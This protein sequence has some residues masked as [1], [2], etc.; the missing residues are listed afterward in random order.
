MYIAAGY[1]YFIKLQNDFL[2]YILDHGE[3][4]PYLKCYF[5]NI[6][7]KIPIYEAN[8][9]QILSINSMFKSSEYKSFFE[10]VNTYTRRKIY[11]ND[12]SINYLNY[13]ELEFDFQGIEEELAKLILPGKC[14]FEDENNLNFIKYLGEGFNGG[15]EDFLQKF[16]K[17]I[18]VPEELTKDDK[19]KINEYIHFNFIDLNGYRYIYGYV[20]LLIIYLAD[21]NFKKDE[22]ICDLIY[23]SPESIKTDDLCLVDFFE[24][25]KVNKLYSIF[26]FIE[27]L[28]FDL[29]SRNILKEYKLDIDEINK[30]KI[31]EIVKNKKDDIKGLAPAVRRFISRIL[32]IIEDSNVLLPNTNLS[33]ELKKNLNLWDIEFRNEQKINEILEPFEEFNLK[34]GQSLNLY[35]IIVQEEKFDN[36]KDKTEKDMKKINGN[37]LKIRKGKR[38]IKN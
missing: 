17:I 29:F 24:G 14:L 11:N 30:T 27:Y 13:N 20:Q 12:G 33:V 37:E 1:E 15:K 32:Y 4:K 23:N 9:N 31:I 26:L 16:E 10:I 22:K 25:F 8:N 38:R 3:D 34:V 21:I 7:N 18:G 5:D 36:C 28:C 6:K 19:I 35:Q 2:N